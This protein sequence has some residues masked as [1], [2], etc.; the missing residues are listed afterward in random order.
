MAKQKQTSKKTQTS[1]ANKSTEDYGIIT[2][3]W[4]ILV[5]F[6][7][8][9]IVVVRE[10]AYTFGLVYKNFYSKD[11]LDE[12]INSSSENDKGYPK[13][14]CPICNRE[15]NSDDP[16][17]KCPEKGCGEIYH[18]ICWHFSH[19]CIRPGCLASFENPR[20]LILH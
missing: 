19:G 10:M 1:T 12:V 18:Y 2:E 14:V 7:G 15:F 16:V 8:F 9:C 3:L 17:V 13:I 11:S 4:G 20:N 6:S 5:K